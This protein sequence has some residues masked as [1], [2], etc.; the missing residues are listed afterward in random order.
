MHTLSIK[1]VAEVCLCCCFH[2]FCALGGKIVAKWQETYTNF[3]RN[4]CTEPGCIKE[5]E[6][7]IVHGM[8]CARP[9][10]LKARSLVPLFVVCAAAAAAL[11]CGM[12]QNHPPHK[13]ACRRTHLNGHCFVA[14]RKT[15]QPNQQLCCWGF[16]ESQRKDIAVNVGRQR[17]HVTDQQT[18]DNGVLHS[19]LCEVLSAGVAFVHFVY[20]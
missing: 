7:R 6:L 17:H 10:F 1:C 15:V 20:I 3:K 18:L 9:A 5:D 14:L 11:C 2:F 8:L 16:G 4:V 19:R 12:C 13:R